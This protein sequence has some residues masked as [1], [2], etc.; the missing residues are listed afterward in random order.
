MSPENLSK[1]QP[2]AGSVRVQ[3]PA[4]ESHQVRPDGAG[5]WK[6]AA[7]GT[8]YRSTATTELSLKTSPRI[9]PLPESHRVLTPPIVKA[10]EMPF[11]ADRTFPMPTS[12]N[13]DGR[14]PQPTTRV[15]EGP[16]LS[17]AVPPST[18]PGSPRSPTGI[19]K[20]PPPPR[21]VSVKSPEVVKSSQS[22]DSYEMMKSYS[23]SLSS[24]SSKFSHTERFFDTTG[25]YEYAERFQTSKNYHDSK[26][27]ETAKTQPVP[28]QPVPSPR[29]VL[30]GYD[31][32]GL[33]YPIA[34]PSRRETRNVPGVEV[35][36]S[37]SVGQSAT[38]A[39]T[40]PAAVDM[41]FSYH[42]MTQDTG[43]GQF[44]TSSF[45]SRCSPAVMTQTHQPTSSASSRAAVLSTHYYV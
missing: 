3:S 5:G 24:E 25:S 20:P 4:S 17:S 15:G 21:T 38:V 34:D 27:E 33:E 28:V 35:G 6:N 16:L 31:T 18:S 23:Q 2:A 8:V 14:Q 45:S 26:P 12:T 7:D 29:R 41:L 19:S 40:E 22:S 1:I 36:S 32:Q 43:D 37:D 9:S 10:G 13:G 39:G 42:Q 30:A 44:S 11:I